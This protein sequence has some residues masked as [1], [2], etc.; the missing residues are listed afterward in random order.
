[1]MKLVLKK[2][3]WNSWRKLE[4]GKESGSLRWRT[5]YFWVETKSDLKERESWTNIITLSLFWNLFVSQWNLVCSLRPL[6]QMIQTIYMGGV[7]AGAILY[8]GLADRWDAL[9]QMINILV[10]KNQDQ[11][12]KFHRRM[13]SSMCPSNV[14]MWMFTVA[15]H[16]SYEN[17]SFCLFLSGLGGGLSWYG[18]TCSS[19]SSAV[20]P[21]SLHHTPPT[22][23]WGFWVGWRCLESSWMPSHWVHACLSVSICLLVYQSVD[24]I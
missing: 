4:T 23:S 20:A 18:R 19:A 5:R 22:A 13:Y 11:P 15:G 14:L 16:L 6:K 7:L 1:M 3:Y 8:G 21:P 12:V 10:N 2:R 24:W 17:L 9:V